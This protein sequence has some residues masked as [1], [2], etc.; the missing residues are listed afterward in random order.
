MNSIYKP[1][2]EYTEEDLSMRFNPPKEWYSRAGHNTFLY[3]FIDML[4]CVGQCDN[5]LEIGTHKGE[6]TALVASSG[7]VKNIVTIDVKDYEKIGLYHEF[8][9]IE[10]ML[11][12]SDD[13]VDRFEDESFDMIYIDGDHTYEQVCKDI[14]NYLPKVKN[15][16]FIGGHDYHDG[17]WPEVVRAVNERLESPTM[18]FQDLSWV[19]K[20]SK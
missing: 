14:D 1:A 19:K 11:G 12:H 9:N 17:A 13:L 15:G 4:R 7:Q 3:G 18:T 20:I 16:G 6:S 5:W 10:F 8:D 2:R